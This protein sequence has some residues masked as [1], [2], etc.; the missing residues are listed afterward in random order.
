MDTPSPNGGV[1][2][3]RRF[4][5]SSMVYTFTSRQQAEDFFEFAQSVFKDGHGKLTLESDPPLV[6][7]SDAYPDE[8]ALFIARAL[9]FLRGYESCRKRV[10]HHLATSI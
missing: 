10:E 5:R 7:Y 3:N 9:A 8:I 4:T 1:K 2:L 6:K